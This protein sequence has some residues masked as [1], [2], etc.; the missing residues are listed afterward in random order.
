MSQSLAQNGLSINFFI[1]SISSRNLK[2]RNTR[3]YISLSK[4]WSTGYYN[5][6][7][8]KYSLFFLAECS[9]F[10]FCFV[11]FF[12]FNIGNGL[13]TPNISTVYF[14]FWPRSLKLSW[15]CRAWNIQNSLS[16]LHNHTCG[17]TTGG[18][19]GAGVRGR[20]KPGQWW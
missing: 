11:F 10:L 12:F 6:S 3:Q 1:V 14:L 19:Q 13:S 7:S 9:F 15:L 8:L 4:K 2:I 20:E 17:S 16:S 18:W 5:Y